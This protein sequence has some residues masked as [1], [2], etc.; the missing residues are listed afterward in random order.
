[1]NLT[2]EQEQVVISRAKFIQVVA[3]PGS[4]KSTTLV[5]RC[6]FLPEN[7][8]KLFIAFNT[9]VKS[10]IEE[11]MIKLGVKNSKSMTFHGFALGQIMRHP[12]SFGFSGKKVDVLKDPNSFNIVKQHRVK[13]K[14]SKFYRSWEDMDVDD[15]LF[16]QMERMYY[17]SEIDRVL[18]SKFK[19]GDPAS[20]Q[21]YHTALAV[22]DF[23]RELISQNKVTFNMMGRLVAQNRGKIVNFYDHILV[24]ESQDIDRFQ[25]D[26]CMALHKSKKLQS[27]TFVGDEKQA[28]YQFRGVIPNIF[29]KLKAVEPK[30][31][32]F[33][34]SVNFRSVDQV[35]NHAESI[36]N[37]G[38]H[39][40]R[41]SAGGSLFVEPPPPTVNHA[42]G[43]MDTKRFLPSNVNFS[44]D[45]AEHA[46][47]CRFNRDVYKWKIKFLKEG[48][49]FFVIR[50][51]S[52]GPDGFWDTPHM[53]NALSY[54]ERML[55]LDDFFASTEWQQFVLTMENI[56][57]KT[58]FQ[59]A[60]DD[61]RWLFTL[62]FNELNDA[63][64]SVD[65]PNGV[66]ISTIH[67]VKGKEF[68]SVLVYNAMKY[69]EAEP[70]LYYVA[71]T[72]A[73]DNL[74]IYN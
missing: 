34:L 11:R 46:V 13:Q 59:E 70:F 15:E 27:I 21:R 73:K 71:C 61:V 10:E 17:D 14:N 2:P 40:V 31:E 52:A 28:I 32:R 29:D 62:T 48:V 25:F 57:D 45:L 50:G 16:K 64:K 35:I 1:M 12:Q 7:D 20:T 26:S 72:R 49:P 18:A 43:Q 44:T 55:D 58:Y 33:G 74:Y 23:R 54:K 6:K 60:Q 41:G 56:E 37:V 38:M 5:H 22:K 68:G 36:F 42:T 4:G 3:C 66:R 51:A 63:K 30:F 65:S 8:K 47:L 39:G 9:E 24:D 53:K 67:K 69:K 19:L